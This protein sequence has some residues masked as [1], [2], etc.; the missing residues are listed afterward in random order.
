MSGVRTRTQEIYRVTLVGAVVN[1][2][3][4]LLK[5]FVGIF[6]RSSVLVADAVHSFSDFATDIIVILFVRIAGKPKDSDHRYGHGKYESIATLIVSLVLIGVGVG[7]FW[8]SARAIY[9]FYQGSESFAKPSIWA[10]VIAAISIGA[11]EWLFRY[12]KGVALKVKSD[13][14]LANAWEHRSDAYTSFASLVGIGGAILLGEEWRVLDPIACAVVSFF[15]VKSGFQ[16]ALS[17]WRE[18]TEHSLPEAEQKR[19]LEIIDEH[20]PNLHP[21]NLNTRSLGH[22]IAIEVDIYMPDLTPLQ[23]AHAMATQV[24]EVLK[25]HFGGNS[26]VIVHVEPLAVM[27]TDHD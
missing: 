1:I 12:T 17:P 27:H 26:H 13:T 9:S 14:V 4:T 8:S 19:I 10:A 23:E 3:L 21:H 5:L 25:S 22:S 16:I 11:K 18:I 6:G 7:L 2:L 24:E 15:V 20:T